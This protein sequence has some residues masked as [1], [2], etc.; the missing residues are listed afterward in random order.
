MKRSTQ[1][2]SECRN[3]R[4]RGILCCLQIPSFCDKLWA[5]LA[6]APD[7]QYTPIAPP[8]AA[9]LQTTQPVAANPDAFLD[10][11]VDSLAAALEP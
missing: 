11:D 5:W 3:V 4:D 9:P 7:A 6:G 10:V 1:Y 8:D 2:C